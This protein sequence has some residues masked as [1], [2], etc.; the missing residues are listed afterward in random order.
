MTIQ[1]RLSAGKYKL[2]VDD[3]ERLA[4][5]GAFGGQRTE[6]IDGEIIVMSPQYRPHGMVKLELYDELLVASRRMRSPL[7]P[8]TEFSLAL[9]ENSMPD[10]DI[11]LTSEPRGAKAV[12]VTSVALIIEVADT[13]LADDLGK[14]L[15]LY[16]GRGIPEYWIADVNA[17]VIHQMWAPAGERYDERREIAFGDRIT[18][19][20]VAGLAVDTAAL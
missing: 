11:M 4:E 16:A 20:T 19:A 2:S 17:R 13:T 3:Y 8:V 18:A 9:A 5:T 14:K 15:R 1:E 10:P 7:R 12:P 6:L